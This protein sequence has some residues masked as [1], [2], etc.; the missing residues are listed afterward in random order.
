MARKKSEKSFWDSHPKKYRFFLNLYEDQAFTKCPK[1]QTKTKVRKFALVIHIQPKNIFVLNKSCKLCTYCELI[2]AKKQEIESLMAMQFLQVNPEIV[3]NDYLIMG[4][5]ESK[6]WKAMNK[7]T[8]PPDQVMKQ[9]LIF[10]EEW[11]FEVIPAR[12]TLDG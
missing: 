7:G 12:W 6:D 3:G 1:C 5:L 4:T 8:L 10:R 11:S 9:M 2:I